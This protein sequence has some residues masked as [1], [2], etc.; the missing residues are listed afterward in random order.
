[1]DP[2]P[3]RRIMKEFTIAEISAVDEPAQAPALMSIMKSR[4]GNEPDSPAPVSKKEANMPKTAEELQAELTKS[5]D[6]LTKAQGTIEELK[7]K[8]DRAG[9]LA[10]LTDLQKAYFNTLDDNSKDAFLAKSASDRA[11]EVE[12]FEENKKAK[13]PVIYK[14]KD[15]T[16]YRKSDDARL[17]EMAKRDDVREAEM[18]KMR[19]E[20]ANAA[21]EKV[22]STAYAKFR[23]EVSTKVALAKAVAGIDDETTRDA[24]KVML[25]AAHDAV[26]LTLTEIGGTS[27]N[28]AG[29]DLPVTGT[30]KAQAEAQLDTLAKKYATDNQVDY[31]KAYTAVLETGEGQSLYVKTFA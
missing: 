9:T 17:V 31:A 27:D 24:V 20:A 7:K 19:D 22:A 25:K 14:A 18:A 16:E 10:E 23:G 1:M 11:S 12:N 15:G 13:D 6:D 2:K 3:K 8:A 5:A 4:S 29:D 30:T 21:F 26:G 28:Y